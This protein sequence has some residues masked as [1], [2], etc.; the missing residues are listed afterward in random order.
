MLAV[1]IRVRMHR[2]ARRR[3]DTVDFFHLVMFPF[4][5]FSVNRTETD[6]MAAKL[7]LC[8]SRLINHQYR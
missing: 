2:T 7:A 4:N 8:K 3:I 1:A 5:R 6:K